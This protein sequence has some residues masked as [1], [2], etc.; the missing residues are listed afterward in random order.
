[1][2]LALIGGT[3]TPHLSDLKA[4]RKPGASRHMWGKGRWGGLA[5]ITEGGKP[6]TG[7]KNTFG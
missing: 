3:S 5:K 4:A 7:Y 6:T 2:V 1:M